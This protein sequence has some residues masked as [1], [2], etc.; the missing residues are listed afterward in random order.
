MAGLLDVTIQQ[1]KFLGAQFVE[2]DKAFQSHTLVAKY[3]ELNKK[4]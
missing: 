2:I 4:Y 1:A 3:K